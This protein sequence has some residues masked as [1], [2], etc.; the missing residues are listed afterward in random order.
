L[1]DAVRSEINEKID[2]VLRMISTI[3]TF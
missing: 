1:N 2:S 3:L